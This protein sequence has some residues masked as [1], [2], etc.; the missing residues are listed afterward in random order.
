MIGICVGHGNDVGVPR[1]DTVI[2]PGDTL[3]P[4]GRAG[5]LK[6]VER[7]L[8]SEEKKSLKNPDAL[9]GEE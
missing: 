2:H 5:G 4:Y 7:R 6:K 8:A 1:G 9:P 3:V